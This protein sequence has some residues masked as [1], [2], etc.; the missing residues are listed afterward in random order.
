VANELFETLMRFYWEVIKPEFD[1]LR[2]PVDGMVT[3]SDMLGYLDD[4]HARFDRLETQ[5]QEVRA[6]VRRVE[7]RVSTIEQKLE[8]HR[9]A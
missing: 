4:I 1:Q 6:A 3:K 7:V 2:S 9:A 5:C 8:M